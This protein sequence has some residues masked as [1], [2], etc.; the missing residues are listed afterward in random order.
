MTLTSGCM[1]LMESNLGL[2]YRFPT[3]ETVVIPGAMNFREPL[4]FLASTIHQASSLPRLILNLKTPLIFFTSF[5]P[6]YILRGSEFNKGEYTR[7]LTR[8]VRGSRSPS[9]GGKNT[10]TRETRRARYACRAGALKS[11]Q[12]II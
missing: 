1:Q 12:S 5:G 4:P 9:F 8:G 2:F 7:E 10:A 11:I 6:S 3:G